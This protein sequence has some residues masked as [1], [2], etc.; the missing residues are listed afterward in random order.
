MSETTF[1]D[2][3]ETPLGLMLVE[4]TPRGVSRI[5]FLDEDESIQQD[6]P[7]P[8][9]MDAIEWLDNYFNGNSKLGFEF[10]IDLQGTPFQK[11]VWNELCKVQYGR[12][13]SY[14]D[15]SERIGNP[16]AIRAV[17]A[18]NG[19][20]PIALAIPCHRVIGSDGSLTGYAGGIGRKKWLLQH[21]GHTKYGQEQLSMF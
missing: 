2:Y 15:I 20:N 13:V 19:Q 3:I 9:T 10:A 18:A 11:Q 17:G 6:R 12:V 7:N 1:R 4:A 5:R 8:H 14:L 16:K 21:E